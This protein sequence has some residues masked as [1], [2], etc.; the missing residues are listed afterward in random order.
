MISENFD[1]SAK[2]SLKQAIKE[3]L[4]TFPHYSIRFSIV[5]NPIWWVLNKSQLTFRWNSLA[6]FNGKLT[7]ATND[8]R[9]H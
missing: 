6:R 8:P 2:L 7:A 4:Q 1:F 3:S 9:A 5:F